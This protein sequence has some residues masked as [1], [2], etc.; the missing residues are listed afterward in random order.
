ML[1]KLGSGLSVA[2]AVCLPASAP[3]ERLLGFEVDQ[4]FPS[5]K[6]RLRV[7]GTTTRVV[8]CPFASRHPCR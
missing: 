5:E 7:G 1:G 4:D 8:L 2:L 6:L 3:Y